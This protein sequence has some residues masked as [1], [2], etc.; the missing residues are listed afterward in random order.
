[1]AG[2]GKKNVDE[3]LLTALACGASAE[4]AAEKAQASPRTVYRRLKD[5]G[6]QEKLRGLRF[7]MV[8]RTSGMLTAA[9]L[10]AVKTLLALQGPAS[11]PGVRYSA[12]RAILELGLRVREATDLEERIAALE[13]RLQGN[14]HGDRA[15]YPALKCVAS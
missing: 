2:R 12:A 6:F 7:S 11:P 9:S 14:I 3:A 1:M 15:V 10:E 13:A 4:H 5:P 8:Q